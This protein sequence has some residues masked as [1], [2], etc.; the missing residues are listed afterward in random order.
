M[1][2]PALRPLRI[3]E[4]LDASVKLYLANARVLIGLTAVVI[5]PFE[6]LSGLVLLSIVPSSSDLPNGFSAFT[7]QTTAASD[8]AAQTGASAVLNVGGLIAGALVTG[9]CVKAVSDLYLDQPADIRT[10]L[11]FVAR[12]LHSLIWVEILIFLGVLVGFILL[13]VPGIYAYGLWVVAVPALLV[14]R[15]KGR[16][17]LG[18]SRALVRG[19]WWH[20]VATVFVATLMVSIIASIVQGVLLGIFFVTSDSVVVGVLLVTLAQTV[21]AL[22]VRP[23]AAVVITVVYYDLRVRREGYD[24]E[25]LAEQLGFEPGA[26][27]EPYLGPGTVGRPGGP[28]YWPPPPGWTLPDEAT[29]SGVGA[30]APAPGPATWGPESVGQPGGPPYWPPPPGWEPPAPDADPTSR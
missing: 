15:R 6:V 26:L 19:N 3:G 21:A 12:R 29:A 18:R 2:A 7:T 24:V 1:T 5:V 10:S 25:L 11:A 13:I 27:G 14:E 30:A 4:M 17:A 16:R 9:A 20:A 23:F 8:L 22:I 28:P